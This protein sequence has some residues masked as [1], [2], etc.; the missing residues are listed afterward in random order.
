MNNIM[1]ISFYALVI[2]FLASPPNGNA[3]VSAHAEPYL[4]AKAL[5]GLKQYDAALYMLSKL[6][7]TE[8]NFPA[9]LLEGD[10]YMGK[11]EYASALLAYQKGATLAPETFAYPLARAY[12]G[13]AQ[14]D[15][16][17]VW[18]EKHLTSEYRKAESEIQLDPAFEGLERSRGWR[19]LWSKD[20]YT[21][22]E[23]TISRARYLLNSG[24]TTA[25]LKFLN[26][27]IQKYDYHA[28]YQLRAQVYDSLKN[29]TAA[30]Q[31]LQKALGGERKP[32]YYLLSANVA[33]KMEE[34]EKAETDAG[35]AL[36]LDQ[37]VFD[38]YVIR[39]K[40]KAALGE[41]SRALSDIDSYLAYFPDDADAIDLAGAISL[42]DKN[43]LKALAYYNQALKISKAEP[44]YF[45]GR[46]RAYLQTGMYEYAYKDF[47]MALDLNPQNGETWYL[48]GLA[49]QHTA[50]AEG[51]CNDFEKAFKRGYKEALRELQENCNH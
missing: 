11:K 17:L 14:Y 16:A 21:P 50:D 47:S 2:I 13:N 10:L 18:L 22:V 1:K 39:A 27:S 41:N 33:L 23:K 24:N 6:D 3:Q 12:A 8:K 42:K 45:S 28:L 40:A 25:T 49:R 31:D 37:S 44:E 7:N 43:Y 15:S 51:A 20:Y 9:F 34:F 35:N 46:G 5:C 38:A 29:Y 19:T 26:D 48:K 30:Y 36:R 32:E 4:K